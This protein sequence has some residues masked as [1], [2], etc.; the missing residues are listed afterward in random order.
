MSRKKHPRR[1]LFFCIV[2][3]LSVVLLISGLRILESTVFVKGHV[4]TETIRSK[5]ITVDGMDYF[6]RQDITVIMVLGIDETG[7]VVASESYNNTGEADMVAL[8]VF[9]NQ[10]KI[11]D[12]I[13]L[14]RDTMV[15]MPVL[16]VGGKNAGT[17][18]GQLALS[19]TY[20]SG[21]K[22]SCEN[23]RATVSNLLGGITID[24]Y[25]AM[26]MDAIAIV[27]DAVGGVTV[28]VTEDFSD[29]DP[30][31]TKGEITLMGD[32]AIHFVQTRKGVGD[33][34]NISRI[35]RQKEYMEN[36]LIAFRAKGDDEVFVLETYDA[37]SPYM[38]TDCTSKTMTSLLSRYGD[39]A[40]GDM[41]SPAGENVMGEQYYEFHVDEE[42]L[43]KLVVDLFYAP[44]K[45]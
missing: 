1:V 30:T 38:V 18:Y 13:C 34:K 6:P 44:K 15:E 12:V 23:T 10:E 7:P 45:K 21:L 41:I 27:N 8:L 35:E 24:Y 39:Y 33:Q 43:R 40:L 5:T 32:Q 14:N 9:D 28:N 36:F 25:V 19:H 26:N 20:G 3:I 37:V 2:L 22:D 42:Q 4:P 29:V 31:I 11:C 16:G 17:R